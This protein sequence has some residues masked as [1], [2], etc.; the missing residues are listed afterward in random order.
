M[1]VGGSFGGSFSGTAITIAPIIGPCPAFGVF[2]FRE[3]RRG[4]EVR[5]VG[6]GHSLPSGLVSERDLIDAIRGELVRLRATRNDV[7]PIDEI[8]VEDRGEGY[9]MLKGSP[10]RVPD[11]HWHGKA[12][13]IHGRLAGLPDDGGPEAIVSEFHEG[14]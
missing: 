7:G 1:Q 6:G 10:R 8:R 14:V 5:P 9:A 12:G 3:D 13:E 11:F 4:P 2:R